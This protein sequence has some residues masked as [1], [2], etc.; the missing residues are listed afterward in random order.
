MN[1][2]LLISLEALEFIE[3]LPKSTRQRLRSRLVAMLDEPAIYSDYAHYDANGRRLDVHIF[4]PYAVY[5]WDDFAD[6]DLK[7][8]RICKAD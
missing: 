2:R 7:I 3:A 4:G 8:I 5:F 1:Y 6:H